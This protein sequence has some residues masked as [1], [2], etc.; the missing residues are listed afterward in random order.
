MLPGEQ[1][2]G[3]GVQRGRDLPAALR[4]VPVQRGSSGDA[5]PLTRVC[6]THF[7]IVFAALAV[8]RWIDAHTGWSIRKFVRTA[9]RY[10]AIEI[11]AGP[12]PSPPPTHSSQMSA[13]R[14]FAMRS[15]ACPGGGSSWSKCCWLTRLRHTPTPLMSSGYLG[16]IGPT[17]GRCLAR[18]RVL[19]QAS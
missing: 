16:S 2:H 6:R 4:P 3:V 17:R 13:L 15:P 18:L 7:T 1:A 5:P 9:R 12:A 14:A 19:L 10:R 11:Q 8:S